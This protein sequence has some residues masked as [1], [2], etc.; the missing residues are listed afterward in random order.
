M[1]FSIFHGLAVWDLRVKL[2]IYVVFLFLFLSSRLGTP[3]LT[4]IAF[5]IHL[6]IAQEISGL[7]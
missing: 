1:L 3:A 6:C 2:L 7:R 5:F 4:G